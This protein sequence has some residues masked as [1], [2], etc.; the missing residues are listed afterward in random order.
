[1]SQ[2]EW[3]EAD[4]AFDNLHTLENF[5]NIYDNQAEMVVY[6]SISNSIDADAKNIE[7]KKSKVESAP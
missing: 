3:Q 4:M 2:T 1:M 6:E 7:I 5:D